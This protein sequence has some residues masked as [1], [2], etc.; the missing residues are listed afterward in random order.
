[1]LDKEEAILLRK[2]ARRYPGKD[3]APARKERRLAVLSV[4]CKERKEGTSALSRGSVTEETL[5]T[6]GVRVNS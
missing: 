4:T 5:L 2:A 6:T 3:E 1:M